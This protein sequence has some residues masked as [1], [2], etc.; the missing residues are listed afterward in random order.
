MKAA[1]QRQLD[2]RSF[3]K[4][5][6]AGAVSASALGLL[7]DA[8]FCASPAPPSTAAATNMEP[9]PPAGGPAKFSSALTEAT[10]LNGPPHGTT[11]PDALSK[12]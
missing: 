4:S 1:V 3:F 6:G 8:A 10:L 12:P 7:G 11:L 5:A 9:M 2:R